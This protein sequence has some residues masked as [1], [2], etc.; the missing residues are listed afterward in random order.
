M[1]ELAGRWTFLTNHARVLRVIA[2][3]PTARIRDIAAVCRISE[4]AAQGI[5][6]DLEQA[7]YLSRK[8]VGRRSH[9]TLHLD[10]SLRHPA[11]AHLTVRALL[12]LFTDHDDR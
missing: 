8:R 2:R 5:V 1:E 9:Y 10:G 6:R 3:E 12:D 4:R 7:G 11:E